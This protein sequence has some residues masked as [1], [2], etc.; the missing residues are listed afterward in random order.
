M[1]WLHLRH[2][3]GLTAPSWGPLVMPSYH[4]PT[5]PLLNII[6]HLLQW[7]FHQLCETWYIT[8]RSKLNIS[9]SYRGMFSLNTQNNSSVWL[10]TIMQLHINTILIGGLCKISRNC[11]MDNKLYACMFILARYSHDYMTDFFFYPLENMMKQLRVS[12]YSAH[13]KECCMVK[14]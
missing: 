3:S 6:S 12:H 11:D 1:Y 8:I 2:L 14:G 7:A 5:Q 10:L 9:M 13:F 4:N